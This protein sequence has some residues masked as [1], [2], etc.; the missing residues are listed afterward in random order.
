[1][2]SIDE[3]KNLP[4]LLRKIDF[5]R[6]RIVSLRQMNG[7]IV[8]SRKPRCDGIP[9][10]QKS[11]PTSKIACYL[12]DEISILEKSLTHLLTQYQ[13]QKSACEEIISFLD[14]IREQEILT[15]RY[16]LNLDNLEIA[17]K[18]GYSESHIRKLRR[19]AILHFG[20]L[21]RKLAKK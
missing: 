21:C 6:E 3:L 8:L 1:M 10:S 5:F 19:S 13:E 11:D 4:N 9:S 2:P 14:D 12:A 18:L 20:E 17:L 16:F 15:Y 7:N